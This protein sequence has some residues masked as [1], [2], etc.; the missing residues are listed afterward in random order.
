[1][2]T[3][4]SAIDFSRS[5]LVSLGRILNQ[6]IPHV[7]AGQALADLPRYDDHAGTLC[8]IKAER[9]RPDS[10]LVGLPGTLRLWPDSFE[11]EKARKPDILHSRSLKQKSGKRVENILLVK[12]VSSEH[13][14]DRSL[15]SVL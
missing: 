5:G 2:C 13:T 4:I 8:H 1:M 3:L 7:G 12:L 14:S 10:I 11:S 15:S 9:R 6:R